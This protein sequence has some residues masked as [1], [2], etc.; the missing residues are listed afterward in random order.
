MVRGC[1]F[2]R[3]WGRREGEESSKRELLKSFRDVIF[4]HLWST[5]SQMSPNL[6]P[7]WCYRQRESNFSLLAHEPLHR[8]ECSKSGI[9]NPFL[10]KWNEAG[11]LIWDHVSEV[12]LSQLQHN[13]WATVNSS[14]PLGSQVSW[15]NTS[16]TVCHGFHDVLGDPKIP[17]QLHYFLFSECPDACL[18]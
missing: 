16:F 7:S 15:E 4:Q 6:S 9:P 14:W 11:I 13:L 3:Q 8:Q 10:S 18:V 12:Y 5:L 2:D 1:W 17:F